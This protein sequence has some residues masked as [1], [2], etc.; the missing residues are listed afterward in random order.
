MILIGTRRLG[1]GRN[2]AG[3]KRPTKAKSEDPSSFLST[4]CAKN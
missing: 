2:G 3:K 1:T 4:A